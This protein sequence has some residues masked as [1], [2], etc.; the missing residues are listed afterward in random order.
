MESKLF[1][2]RRGMNAFQDGPGN[3][4]VVHMQG[5]NLRCPWCANPESIPLQGVQMATTPPKWSCTEIGV[6]A[7]VEECVQAKPLLFGG[8][9]IT[10]T[11]GEPTM[12]FEAL[13]AALLLCRARGIHTC[14]ESNAA[15][16]HLP[17]LF[18]L[19]DFLIL[20][21]KHYDSEAHRRWTGQG[22]ESI[23][24][25][26]RAAGRQR[27]QL[28][29]RIPVVGGVNATVAD[30]AA[31]RKH[32]AALGLAHCPVEPLRYHAYGKPKW[33]QCGMEY[34]MQG[35]DLTD[36]GWAAFCAALDG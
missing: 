8:G 16:P 14:I 4:F 21:C 36:A 35:A 30:A 9:G 1:I 7:L 24:E 29:L 13:R 17:E 32:F 5:C 22:N 6:A 26:L 20:D 12:Q 3:R 33:R 2:L 19:I 18:P 11:G 23:T 25:N 31:F 10:F 28:L 27:E 15:H 34:T